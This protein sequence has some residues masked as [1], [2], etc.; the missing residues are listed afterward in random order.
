MTGYDQFSITRWILV[1][2]TS[3]TPGRLEGVDRR[4]FPLAVSGPVSLAW[5]INR[6]KKSSVLYSPI[7][8]SVTISITPQFGTRLNLDTATPFLLSSVILHQRSWFGPDNGVG[9]WGD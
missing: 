4:A 3:L 1:F 9:L 7:S 8:F 2:F 5:I 6:P